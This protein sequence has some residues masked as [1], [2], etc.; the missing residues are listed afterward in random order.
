MDLWRHVVDVAKYGTGLWRRRTLRRAFSAAQD[1]LG[2]RMYAAG[3]DDGQL[4][5]Q[6]AALDRQMPLA[7]VRSSAKALVVARGKLIRQLAASALAE[8]APLPGA[9][10]EYRKARAAQTAAGR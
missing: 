4:G 1:H 7:A 10:G 2:E 9:E 8:E 5:A 3:I 6:I